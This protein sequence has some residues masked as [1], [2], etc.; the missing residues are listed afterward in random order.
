MSITSPVIV[1]GEN[2][3]F[4]ELVRHRGGGRKGKNFG[5][6]DREHGVCLNASMSVYTSERLNPRH[7]HDFD[8]VRYYV[9]GGEN[10]TDQTFGPGDCVYFPEG[11]R[12]G[13][14][15]TAEGSDENVRLNMQFQ[16]P[17]KRP[18]FQRVDVQKGDQTL[19]ELGGKFEK[20]LYLWPDG[21][22]Q[23]SAEAIREHLGGVKISYPEPRY[24]DYVV[25]HSNQYIWQPVN[26]VQGVDVK[27]LG[28][29]NESGPNI[30]MVQIA[31]GA[32]TLC[33]HGA[34]PAGALRHR[35]RNHFSGRILR[36][37]LMHVF[38]R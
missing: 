35:R 21:R 19:L 13:P 6:L 11:V 37:D 26:G 31:A 25:M 29:F 5:F 20:G 7:R 36:S 15:F 1:R 34:L 16:G 2:M 22:K 28:Y 10:Y 33:R 8:Q 17:A 14:T 27:H 30:K 3:S 9:R 18:F 4:G 32:S 23:D 24:D 38:S 12:Y